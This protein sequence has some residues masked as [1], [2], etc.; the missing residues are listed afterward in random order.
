MFGG[1]FE[2]P[3]LIRMVVGTQLGTG[4]AA[5]AEPAGAVRSR[6]RADGH[7][8]VELRVDSAGLR[9]RDRS[10]RGPV[11]AIEHRLMYDLQFDTEQGAGG[12]TARRCRRG[13]SG[14]GRDVTIVATSIMVVE[15]IRAAEHLS[16]TSGI[17]CE[18][19][20]LN[21]VSHPDASS[22]RRPA[23]GRPDACSS[24]T[25]AGAATASPPRSAASSS[26]ATPR[27]YAH[28]S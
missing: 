21:C 8:A 17:D 2:V 12:W 4:R 5:L 11:I 28:P 19:I 26:S 3:M 20:D 16:Q 15:A 9:A 18:I 10:V 6:A 27:P 25:R 13:S 22:D 23:S 1:R 24:P 14:A 7:H